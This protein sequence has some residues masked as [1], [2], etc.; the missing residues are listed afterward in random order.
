MNVDGDS[1]LFPQL[2]SLSY[3]WVN[4]EVSYDDY[5]YFLQLHA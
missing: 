5:Y 3:T 2:S 4:Q 1:D